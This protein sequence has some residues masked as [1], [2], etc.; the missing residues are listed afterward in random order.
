MVY[1]TEFTYD[2]VISILDKKN[3]TAPSSGCTQPRRICEF[4]DFNLKI[5]SSNPSDVKVKVT[6]DDI[7]L[8]TN[9]T[10]Q[11]PI[12]L[13]KKSISTPNWI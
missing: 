12:K 9:L 13:T 2:P 11:K 1:R 7:R 3:T 4:R 5:K 6:V 10:Y 8:Q